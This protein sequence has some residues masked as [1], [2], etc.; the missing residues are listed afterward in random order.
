MHALL[1]QA[2]PSF[3]APLVSHDWGTRPLH[4]LAPGLQEP[5]QAP[6]LHTL[7]QAVP[8]T[9]APLALQV[10]GVRLEHCLVPGVQAPAQT[11]ATHA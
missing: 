11:P 5:A 8:L 1:E 2:V 3:Q 10:C 7:A 9:H 6:P 4:C